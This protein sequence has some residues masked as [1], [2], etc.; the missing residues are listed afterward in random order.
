MSFAFS[1]RTFLLFDTETMIGGPEDPASWTEGPLFARL[2]VQRQGCRQEKPSG[3][4]ELNMFCQG[5]RTLV[6]TS[7]YTQH[8]LTSKQDMQ[9]E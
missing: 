2:S 1:E 9:D 3:L 6:C 4:G 5:K 8:S 7:A